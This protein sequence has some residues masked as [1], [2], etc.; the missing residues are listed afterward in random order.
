MITKCT[1]WP[2]FVDDRGGRRIYLTQERWEHALNH[3]GMHESLL[4]DVLETLHKG[5]RKQDAYAPAKF[6][7]NYSIQDLPMSYTHIVVVVKFGWQ[8]VPA[9]A[10][11]FVLTA[12]LIEK[13]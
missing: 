2:I 7:Y 4:D 11:N 3:P 10:N 1:D 8:G 12:Y 5:E 9:E 13:W 6:K